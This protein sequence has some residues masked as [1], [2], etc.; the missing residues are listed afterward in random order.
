MN[1]MIL[2]NG[3]LKPLSFWR[4]PQILEE[5]E[6]LKLGSLMDDM[7]FKLRGL[8]DGTLCSVKGND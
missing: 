7:S 2:L 4:K 6:V 8:A 3:F 5:S 1:W